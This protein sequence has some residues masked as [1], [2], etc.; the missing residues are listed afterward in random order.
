MES[1]KTTFEEEC[2]ELAIDIKLA[3]DVANFQVRFATKNEEHIDFFGGKL[4]GVQQVRFTPQDQDKWFH[5]IL[6]IDES[7]VG[8]RLHALPDVNPEYFISSNPMNLSCAWLMHAFWISKLP[9][10]KKLDAMVNVAQVLHYKLLTSLLAHYFPYPADRA[11]AEATYARLSYKFLIKSHASWGAFLRFLSERLVAKGELWERPIRVMD[12]DDEVVRM[13]NDVQSRVRDYVKNIYREFML[14]HQQGI[15]ISSVSAVVEF[16]GKE[17]LRDKTRGRQGYTRY[18]QSII[19]DKRSFIRDELVT[20]IEKVQPSMN[21][22]PFRQCLE[23]LSDNY[24]HNDGGLIESLLEETLIHSFQYLSNNS[25]LLRD[26]HDLSGLLSRLRGTYTS[27]RSTDPSV[28]ELRVK[29][30]KVAK[31]ATGNKNPNALAALRTGIL[32]Y[33]CLRSYTMHFY[34]N[35]VVGT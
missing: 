24:Q 9:D 8:E 16:D 10:D 19:G 3:H 1:I 4:L 5:D 20:I 23:W 14:V 27:S 2:A 29:A 28:L 34:A 18:I 17:I 6:N 31:L 11:T 32:L 22:R 7:T 12:R 25:T 30:E 15:K 35:A 13:L 21:P 26:T 33:I